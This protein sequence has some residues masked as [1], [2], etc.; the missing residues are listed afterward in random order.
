MK[1]H[2]VT[3]R[4]GDTVLAETTNA[5]RI[6]GNYYIPNQDVVADLQP[7]ALTT[8]CYWKGIARYRHLDVDGH[9]IRNV[10][11]T[12]PLPSPFA[13]PIRRMVAFAPEAGITITVDNASGTHPTR[14]E[15][16]P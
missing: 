7:S 12:Y 4:L 13:W 11:W 1:R 9:T 6:E 16:R 8:L 2:A 10:A 5:V 15:T 14:K 3:A